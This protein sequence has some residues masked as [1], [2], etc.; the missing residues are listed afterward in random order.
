MKPQNKQ[1]LLIWSVVILVVLNVSTLATIAYHKFRENEPAGSCAMP[2]GQLEADA[3]KFSGRYFHNQLGF[4]AD[5]MD[6]FR[7][8]NP[9]FR[10]QA[11]A[12]TLELSAKRKQMLDAMASNNVDTVQ[13]NAL[14]DSI[15]YLHSH[16]KKLTY[17]YYLD[18]KSICTPEQ[19][20]KLEQLFKD[21]FTNDQPMSFPGR[22]RHGKLIFYLRYALI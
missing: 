6:R 22:G 18:M 13:L 16:L 2:Q 14:S 9:V 7:E 17:K 10:Q 12:V 21:M 20:Q 15:G 1:S 4:S 5:Q 8:F 3:E 11:R 19:Q